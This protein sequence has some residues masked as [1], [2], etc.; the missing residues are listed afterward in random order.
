[1]LVRTWNL[2]HGNTKPPGRKAD[3]REM[4]ELITADHPAIVCLQEV[5]AWALGSIGPWAGMQGIGDR[6]RRGLPFGRIVTSENSHISGTGLGLYLA[7]TL[8]RLHGGDITVRST[9]GVGTEF[10][11]TL[12]LAVVAAR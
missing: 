1:M 10:T 6:T 11:L 7:R 3:L 4:V 5:P 9:L 2:F 8:A 12:P